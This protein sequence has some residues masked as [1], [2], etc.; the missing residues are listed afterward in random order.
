[1][2]KMCF[3]DAELEKAVKAAIKEFVDY[4][5]AFTGYDVYKL[6]KEYNPE[7]RFERPH[8][9]VYVRELFNEHD[10]VFKG[11]YASFP[12]VIRKEGKC[13]DGPLVYF[14]YNDIKEGSSA[15]SLVLSIAEP[16]Y[17]RIAL[18]GSNVH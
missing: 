2:I 15:S 6:V 11:N 9:S 12:V 14:S 3:V 18:G 7:M 16:I 5:N 4:H 1:M 10:E 8:I 17:R 13:F